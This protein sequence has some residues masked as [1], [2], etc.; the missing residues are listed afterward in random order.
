[1]DK[2]LFLI[3]IVCRFCQFDLYS[4]NFVQFIIVVFNFVKFILVIFNSKQFKNTFQFMSKFFAIPWRVILIHRAKFLPIH[5]IFNL[6]MQ[7]KFEILNPKNHFKVNEKSYNL[8]FIARWLERTE[9]PLYVRDTWSKLNGICKI[10]IKIKKFLW[11]RR[12]NLAKL[13]LHGSEW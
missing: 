13:K 2:K 5:L 1:M 10:L 9:I 4:F 6:E 12:I 11:I 3:P 7:K 8:C